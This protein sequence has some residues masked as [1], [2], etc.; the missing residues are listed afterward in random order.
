[1]ICFIYCDNILQRTFHQ[2]LQQVLIP[3]RM[4]LNKQ[5]KKVLLILD[6]HSTHTVETNLEFCNANGIVP[7]LLP[8]HTSHVIQPLDIGI[9]NSYKAAYRQSATNNA[10]DDIR[11]DWASEATKNRLDMLGRSLIANTRAVTSANIR[12]AFFHSGIYPLS[13][14]HFIFQCKSIRGVPPEVKNRAKATIDQERE[15]R[16][17]RIMSKGRINIVNQILLVDSV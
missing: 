17:Q 16:Q 1:M 15:E 2:W 10:L 8:A 3:Y 14:D 7:C 5:D 4:S 13:I 11:C 12:R 9:F 6:G